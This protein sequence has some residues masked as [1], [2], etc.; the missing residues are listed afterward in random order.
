MTAY[1]FLGSVVSD[2]VKILVIESLSPVTIEMEGDTVIGQEIKF[3]AYHFRGSD[4]TYTWDFGDGIKNV[5]NHI[6]IGHTYTE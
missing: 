6:I 5:T 3:E 2:S 4:V 1:N